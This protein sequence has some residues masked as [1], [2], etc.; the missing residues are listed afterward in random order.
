MN[1]SLDQRFIQKQLGKEV[2]VFLPDGRHLK[3]CI[4]E[5]DELS[6]TLERDG[7]VQLVY[8]APSMTVGPPRTY[9]K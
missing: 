8:K 3:G 5:Q 7:I 6:F 2:S 4:V 9:N 1:E